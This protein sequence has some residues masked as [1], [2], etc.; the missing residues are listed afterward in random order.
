MKMDVWSIAGSSSIPDGDAICRAVGVL[1]ICFG[2]SPGPQNA[3]F[4]EGAI[5]MTCWWLFEIGDGSN[6]VGG[7]SDFLIG[8]QEKD[9]VCERLHI[10]AIKEENHETFMI[11]SC[12]S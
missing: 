6:G 10:I 11:I 7:D 4:D 5:S 1:G 9:V 3:A 8:R 2:V 12:N